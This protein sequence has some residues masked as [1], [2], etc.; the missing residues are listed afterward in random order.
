MVV[1]HRRYIDSKVII[2]SVPV[3]A[4]VTKFDTFVQDVLQKI[5]EAAVDEE[6]DDDTIEKEADGQAKTL[7]EQHYKQPLQ[8]LPFPP[9][10]VV[11]M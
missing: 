9:K 7:Y 10:A 2:L 5:E 1:L 6:L 8:K 3:V 4:I 11:S